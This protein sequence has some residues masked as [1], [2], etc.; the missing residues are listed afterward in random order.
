MT[1]DLSINVKVKWEFPS[2]LRVC[3]SYKMSLCN[4]SDFAMNE[5]WS[6]LD[7]GNDF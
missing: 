3:A 6:R 5:G 4:P 7:R 2:E 1:L